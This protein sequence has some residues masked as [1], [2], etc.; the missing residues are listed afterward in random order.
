MA[1]LVGYVAGASAVEPTAV[2]RQPQGKAA[3]AGAVE[4]TAVVR[5][6]QGKAK[7]ASAVEPTAVVRQP[8]GK[9]AGA[10]AVEPTAVVRQLQGKV[11]VSQGS[12]MVLAQEGMPLY[13]GNRVITV[14]GGRTEVAYADGCVVALLEN[15]LLAVKGSD[16][17]RL[18]QFQVRATGGFQNARIGQAPPPS[19]DIGIDTGPILVSVA[20]GGSLIG[21]ILAGRGG[22]DRPASPSA[23]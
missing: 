19:G 6:P 10:G 1:C 12:A 13:A 15:S 7:G 22:N 14:S 16:Q 4:P 17:C 3:G 8:Q 20:L 5:Q 18:G 23:P 11:F 21:A 9:A 2:V